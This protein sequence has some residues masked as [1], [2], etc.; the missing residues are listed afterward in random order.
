MELV[1]DIDL[2]LI[3]NQL[4][5][6]SG[7]DIRI[8]C[9][10]AAMMSMRRRTSGLKPTEIAAIPRDE[11]TTPISMADLMIACQKVKKTVCSTNIE[12]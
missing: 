5:D 6:Y 1:P 8:V 9:S 11:R 7:S 3:F 4:N 12:K 2:D 10:E